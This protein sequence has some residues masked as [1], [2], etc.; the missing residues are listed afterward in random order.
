MGWM[1]RGRQELQS[2]PQV[3]CKMPLLLCS[4]LQGSPGFSLPGEA[5]SDEPYTSMCLILKSN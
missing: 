5:D 1:A 2:R 4:L 3:A